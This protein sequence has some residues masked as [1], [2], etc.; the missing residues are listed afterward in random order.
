MSPLFSFIAILILIFYHKTCDF[1]TFTEL[2]C[3]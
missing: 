1:S 3:I 2:D